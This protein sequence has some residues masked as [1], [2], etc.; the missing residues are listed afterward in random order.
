MTSADAALLDTNVLVYAMNADAEHHASCR[1]LRDR[2]LRGAIHR[3]AR[4]LRV[5]DW[6]VICTIEPPDVVL[7]VTIGHRK[8]VYER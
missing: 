2:A 3:G 4:R 5:A 6:R 7:V 1:A 8:D